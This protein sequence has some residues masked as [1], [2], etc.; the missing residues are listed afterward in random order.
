[1]SWP[2]PDERDAAVTLA[3]QTAI[4]TGARASHAVAH[5]LGCTPN[6]AREYITAARNRGWDIPYTQQ[7]P[8][9]SRRVDR[10]S[11][12]NNHAVLTC[13]CGHTVALTAWQP[14]PTMLRHTLE[15]H[16]RPARAHERT[17]REPQDVAA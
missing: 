15:A 5:A 2:R 17:P 11:Q 3:A 9:H 4:A 6:R 1:M 8:P 14:G 10:V 7:H 16:G 12:P 13:D